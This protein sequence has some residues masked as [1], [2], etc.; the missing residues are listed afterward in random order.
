[1]KSEQ[2]AQESL[3]QLD[4]S[5]VLA[6]DNV[7][8]NLKRARVESLME[9]I[10]A[11]GKVL[12]PVEVEALVPPS[13][14]HIYRL[15]SGFYRHAA[16]S[17]LNTD[18]KAGLL[19]PAIVRVVEPQER[20]RH[21]LAE[22]MDREN[23]SPMDSAVAIKKLMDME[24]PRGEIRRI[25]S[26]PGSRKG[27]AIEPASNAWV[28]IIL[29]FLTL[30]KTVQEKIHTGAI[31]VEAAYELGKVPP[32]KRAAVIERAEAERARQLEIEAKDEE[33]YLTAEKKMTEAVGKEQEAVS[34]VDEAKA[35]IIAAEAAVTAKT[36]AL[37]LIQGEPYLT[38]DEKGK[39]DLKERLKA[40]ETDLKGA[41]KAEKE[42][43][44]ELA[45]LLGT[46]KK[47]SEVAAE[48][49][50]KLEAARKPVKTAAKKPMGKADIK[51]AAA[52]E[53]T[54][55]GLQPLNASE[56]KQVLKDL[57]KLKEFP[58][59]VAIAKAFTGCF[60]GGTTTKQ[61]GME[62]AVMTGEA[63][64]PPAPKA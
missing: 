36:A 60:D 27:A 37:R 28:N 34:K 25:F 48:Q 62:L 15:T 22:N 38:M 46:A 53:G 20:L 35:A 33:K 16:V 4:P 6:E 14:G 40:S 47:A 8:F 2:E 3:V 18:Q 10:L 30:P 63:K 43:K 39:A 56:V 44:N 59:V 64:A 45:K 17:K 50:A 23:M 49:K 31:G 55:T 42:A 9:S 24:T 57:A 7:R 1:M 61:L 51:A 29:S 58:R 32:D 26:R 52:A 41:Q 12:Q 13:N 54:P 5:K 11:S 19:L 21:Q